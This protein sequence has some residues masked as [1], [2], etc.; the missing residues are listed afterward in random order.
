MNCDLV[1]NNLDL[2]I[3]GELPDDAR[4]ELEQHVSRC[5]EC[6][7]ALLS[8]RQ[9]HAALSG[10]VRQPAGPSSS[11]LAAS[12]MRLQEALEN[13]GQ[14]GFLNRWA[15]DLTGWTHQIK[16]APALTLA[17]LMVGFGAGTLTT[18]KVTSTVFPP[19]PAATG[20]RGEASEASIAGIRDIT[21]DPSSNRVEIKYDTLQPQSVAGTLDDPRVQKLLL[22]AARNNL[23]SGMRMDSIN[24]LTRNPAAR[25]VREAL[26]FALR[27]DQNPGVRLKALEGLRGY[28]KEDTRVRD[29]VL[30]AL[31]TDSNPGV[32]SEAI[33]LLQP[34]SGDSSVRQ[35]LQELAAGDKNTYIR[36]ESRRLIGSLPDM[37]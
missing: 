22:M 35:T 11:F 28:I 18:F 17:L 7:A 19:A 4:Y 9:F 31:L 1:I 37:D 6:A 24:L 33:G 32:R 2:Y 5:P 14:S 15:L 10:A 29:S 16:L 13:T 3:Y 27:Y 12:R 23:N 36:S 25:D 34:V 21:P 30:E 26:M 8:A 20:N